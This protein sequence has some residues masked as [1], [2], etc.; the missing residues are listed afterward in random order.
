MA[1]L[2]LI[3]IVFA[4]NIF[5]N[6]AQYTPNDRIITNLDLLYG[7]QGVSVKF[8]YN[9]TSSS[10]HLTSVPGCPKSIDGIPWIYYGDPPRC[11]L[12]AQHGPCPLGQKLLVIEGSPYGICACECVVDGEQDNSF[13][14][15]TKSCFRLQ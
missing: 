10:N 5:L 2:F 6:V 8:A 11:F 15:N 1:K 12:A 4:L 3:F 13:E 9:E 7:N 14:L